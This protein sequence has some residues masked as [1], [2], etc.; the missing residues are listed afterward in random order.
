MFHQQAAV[1]SHV[2]VL[3]AGAE[4]RE[5]LF[6]TAGGMIGFIVFVLLYNW[7]TTGDFKAGYP[8]YINWTRA[9][10]AEAR[11]FQAER[12]L[13][14]SPVAVETS[15]RATIWL[16]S[17]FLLGLVGGGVAVWA[18]VTT[19]PVVKWTAIAI[20]AV[21]FVAGLA[22]MR[23]GLYLEF[24]AVK[25]QREHDEQLALDHPAEQPRQAWE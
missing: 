25:Q 8:R 23:T 12:R 21:L 10:R 11:R 14:P 2:S 3:A 18:V 4:S 5:D 19:T 20:A 1:T 6:W 16:N 7:R 24:K 17:G 13:R 9:Q 22:P 15:R